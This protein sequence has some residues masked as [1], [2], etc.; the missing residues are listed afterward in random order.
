VCCFDCFPN[1]GECD[2]EYVDHGWSL[3]R[4]ADEGG[5][6]GGR[7][8]R[9]QKTPACDRGLNFSTLRLVFFNKCNTQNSKPLWAYMYTYR[10]RPARF[11]LLCGVS[12]SYR[13]MPIYASKRVQGKFPSRDFGNNRVGESDDH[14]LPRPERSAS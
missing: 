1:S 9:Q 13:L 5:A 10:Y 14:D 2:F 12:C 3:V 4:S 11:E 8:F 7:I 6:R